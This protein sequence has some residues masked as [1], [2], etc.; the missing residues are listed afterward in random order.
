MTHTA[1]ALQ[2]ARAGE[3]IDSWSS[4]HRDELSGFPE[5]VAGA[6]AFANEAE[7]RLDL[8]LPAQEREF[9]ALHL[10][11]LSLRESPR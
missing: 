8:R 6:E 5:A 2:R 9:L 11:S 3:A 10:A 1:L 4:D 7:R